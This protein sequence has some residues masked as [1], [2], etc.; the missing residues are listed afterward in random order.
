MI[1]GKKFWFSHTVTNIPNEYINMMK[2]RLKTNY[3][4]IVK[5]G[6]KSK[7]LESFE[8]ILGYLSENE[9]TRKDVIVALGGGVVGA[10]RAVTDAGWLDAAH[11]VGQTGKTVHPKIYV[12]LGISGAIQHTAGMQD[13]E[14]IIAINK[15]ETA[16]IFDVADYGIV[17][18]L[19][20]IL[21]ALTE[22]LKAEIKTV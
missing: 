21:P 6:E 13:S 7:S 19:N 10:S 4:Y 11:Q 2:N 5:A 9:F 12:A 16:P 8:K 15:N 3:V 1:L 22:K 18:D 17:G 20:K 14:C